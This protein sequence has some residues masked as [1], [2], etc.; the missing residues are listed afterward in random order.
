MDPLQF[1]LFFVA[2][3]VGYALVH[4]RLVR[5]EE[6]LS[7]LGGIR[8][9]DD[10]LRALDDRLR[11]LAESLDKQ[12]GD[13]RIDR[14]EGQLE[15]LHEDL[16][17]LREA[18]TQVRSAVAEIPAPVVQAAPVQPIVEIPR[19]SADTVAT[20][21]LAQIQTRLHDLGYREVRVLNDVSGAR[22]E[23]DVEVQVECERGSMPI[24]G[25]VLLRNGAVRDIALQSVV[26][27]FP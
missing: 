4:L 13:L 22:L 9:L 24:K 6:H 14:V 18:T 8:G 15:R 17:D 3:L 1:S 10:R 12:R 25:R 23:D 20:R 5:F 7:K 19:P 21:L 27:M 26:Q 11:V 16:L 2:L